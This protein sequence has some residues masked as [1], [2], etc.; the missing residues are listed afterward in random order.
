MGGSVGYEILRFVFCQNQRPRIK[1]QTNSFEMVRIFWNGYFYRT[2]YRIA[3]L[4]YPWNIF[5]INN[6]RATR[7]EQCKVSNMSGISCKK[8]L[9][10]CEAEFSVRMLEI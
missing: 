5:P 9:L 4:A 1:K 8:K 10:H 6:E 3:L 7:L 2:L